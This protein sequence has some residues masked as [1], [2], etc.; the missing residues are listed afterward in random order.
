[1][2][3]SWASF[4]GGAKKKNKKKAYVP[5]K[6]KVETSKEVEH[7]R[8]I[9]L[10]GSESGY[11]VQKIGKNIYIRPA[12]ESLVD[13]L[14]LSM[15][16]TRLSDIYDRGEATGFWAQTK[17]FGARAL[18]TAAITSI[19]AGVGLA[20]SGPAAAV[21][22]AAVPFGATAALRAFSDWMRRGAHKISNGKLFL[23]RGYSPAL[24]ARPWSDQS[25]AVIATHGKY[26]IVGNSIYA[27][28]RRST[29]GNR[30]ADNELGYLEL[31]DGTRVVVIVDADVVHIISMGRTTQDSARGVTVK[32]RVADK[33]ADLK[34]FDILGY[35]L[36]LDELNAMKETNGILGYLVGDYTGYTYASQARAPRESV[37]YTMFGGGKDKFV[38]L[39]IEE[40]VI[41]IDE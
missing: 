26:Y 34:E 12:D 15:D 6:P 27:V 22:A 3:Y 14:G 9:L 13:S 18:T 17:Q 5:Y 25:L 35:A 36:S 7:S 21:G 8:P 39:E 33:V 4:G 23:L 2:E 41:E 40:I 20:V 10:R 11:F 37:G 28:N 38:P 19:I 1:M 24:E 32:K 16:F 31:E 30:V 29:R